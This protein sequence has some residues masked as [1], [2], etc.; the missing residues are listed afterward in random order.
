MALKVVQLA[1]VP[2]LFVQVQSL[3]RVFEF[4]TQMMVEQQLLV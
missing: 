3:A 2:S 4:Q 1:R